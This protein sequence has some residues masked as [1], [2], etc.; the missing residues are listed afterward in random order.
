MV[1]T[2]TLWR[3]YESFMCTIYLEDHQGMGLPVIIIFFFFLCF[4]DLLLIS[5]FLFFS[6]YVFQ[7]YSTQRSQRWRLQER[8]KVMFEG[9]PLLQ[10]KPQPFPWVAVIIVTFLPFCFL[11]FFF[12]FW[13]LSPRP[14][15]L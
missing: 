3:E 6:F 10:F 15:P 8:A 5:F 7:A 2:F 4:L 1:S 14:D 13:P 11:L 12:F 9:L